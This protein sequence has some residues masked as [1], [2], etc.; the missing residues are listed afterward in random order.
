MRYL[1]NIGKCIVF[2]ASL[3]IFKLRNIQTVFQ[4]LLNVKV[5]EN[6]SFGARVGSRNRYSLCDN[7]WHSVR[8]HFVKDSLTLRVDNEPEAYGFNGAVKS[9]RVWVEAPLYIGGLPGENSS[10]DNFMKHFI[11]IIS[12][13]VRLLLSL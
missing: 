3:L 6:H 12:T 4:V 8:A 13:S 9:D 7:G 11:S 5:G 2:R 10:L 1:Y